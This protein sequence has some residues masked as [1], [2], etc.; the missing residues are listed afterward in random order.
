M[1]WTGSS[2]I[3][4]DC[5]RCADEGT[6]RGSKSWIPSSV[7]RRFVGVSCSIESERWLAPRYLRI[8]PSTPVPR[9]IWPTVLSTRV[10]PYCT[11]RGVYC[12]IEEYAE[13]ELLIVPPS[14]GCRE[15]SS[16]NRESCSCC[17][18]P[19]RLVNGV[20]I[21][22]VA[23]FN[24]PSCDRFESVTAGQSYASKERVSV[25]IPT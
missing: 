6:S 19:R 14:H 1:A 18:R 11:G 21:E 23:D 2:I 16:D 8:L 5:S 15:L 24:L 12:L 22:E 9:P 20:R 10:A 17:E 7:R 25:H 4:R 13:I 3:G